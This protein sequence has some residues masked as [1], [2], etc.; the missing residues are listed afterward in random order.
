MDGQTYGQMETCTPVAHAKAG[1]TIKRVVC[2]S[3][4]NNNKKTNINL[5]IKTVPIKK[6][7]HNVWVIMQL[8][9]VVQQ[10]Y[11]S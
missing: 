4:N 2:I 5:T 3:N 1:V 8:A 9:L 11:F 7:G 6:L 10:K